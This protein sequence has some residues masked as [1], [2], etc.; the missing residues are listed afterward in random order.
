MIFI[1]FLLYSY[2]FI[3]VISITFEEVG[4]HDMRLKGGIK[5]YPEFLISDYLQVVWK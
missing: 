5:L 3:V 4:F 1:P 2:G